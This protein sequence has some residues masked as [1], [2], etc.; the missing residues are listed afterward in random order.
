MVVVVKSLD[1]ATLNR[2]KLRPKR[3]Y[4]RSRH[5]RPRTHYRGFAPKPAFPVSVVYARHGAVPLNLISISISVFRRTALYQDSYA[6]Y[7]VQ[8]TRE[9][10]ALQD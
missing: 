7:L 2:Q 6:D 9:V 10:E 1:R 8:S 5:R 4:R 3:V